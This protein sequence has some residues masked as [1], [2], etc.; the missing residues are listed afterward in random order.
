M[1]LAGSEGSLVAV[2]SGHLLPLL[3]RGEDLLHRA[4]C[5][6]VEV[7]LRGAA[8]LSFSPGGVRFGRFRLVMSLAYA[9][10]EH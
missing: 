8:L 4:V 9:S 2:V 6:P 7:S 3:L 10:F 5:V 1:F